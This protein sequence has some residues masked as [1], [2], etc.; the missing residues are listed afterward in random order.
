MRVLLSTDPGAGGDHNRSPVGVEYPSPYISVTNG[1]NPM[2]IGNGKFESG[3]SD[4]V[5]PS[6]LRRPSETFQSSTALISVRLSSLSL[7]SVPLNHH[8]FVPEITF[9]WDLWA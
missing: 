7:A 5:Y 9:R 2:K 1:M 4:G 8:S 6:R 3:I